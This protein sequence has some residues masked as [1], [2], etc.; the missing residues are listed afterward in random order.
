MRREDSQGGGVGPIGV[1]TAA[2]DEPSLTIDNVADY[3]RERG[4]LAADLKV[5][6]RELSGG[7]SNRVMH[8]EAPALDV[9]VKQSLSRGYASQT[10]GSLIR[11]GSWPSADACRFS[12]SCCQAA[13]SPEV[14]DLDED[15]L[16]FTMTY[17]PPGG[18]VWKDT[19]LRGDVQLPVARQAGALLG[20]LHQASA[21]R[22]AIAKEFDDLMPTDPRSRRSLP[23]HRREG[24]PRPG[25]AD[26][27]RRRAAPQAPPHV[28]ARRLLPEEPDR[29]S[30]PGSWR[31]TFEVAHWGDP[32]FDTGFMLTHLIAKAVH[33]P[34]RSEILLAAA[35]EFWDAYRRHAG[36]PSAP[37]LRTRRPNAPC[38]CS[39]GWTV[40]PS[41]NISAART[42]KSST[43]WLAT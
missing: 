8:V 18:I 11:D 19:L 4:L 2:T 12:P 31:S 16:A 6:A 35:Q 40:N 5:Q 1:D 9:V 39:A 28:G 30:R 34:D 25:C 36:V 17:A 15:R 26:R 14:L 24:Q 10:S 33:L 29:L 38:S 20:Q 13:R 37:A 32:A 27:R 7:I 42:A 23:P 3:L 43:G 22:P 41:W 21:D